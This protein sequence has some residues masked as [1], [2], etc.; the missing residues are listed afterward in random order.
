MIS[1]IV[2]RTLVRYRPT[3]RRPLLLL[4]LLLLLK[5]AVHVFRILLYKICNFI[6]LNLLQL[7]TYGIF[8]KRLLFIGVYGLC[9]KLFETGSIDVV[10]DC[11]SCFAIDLPSCVLKS[12]QDK[13]ILRY[14]TTVNSYCQFCNKL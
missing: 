5:I 6:V 3:Y 12:R 2:G 1:V 4:L 8:L 14:T 11:L 7:W 10:N 9:M 13:L